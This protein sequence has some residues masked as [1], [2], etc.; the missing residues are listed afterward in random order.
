MLDACLRPETRQVLGRLARQGIKI[1]AVGTPQYVDDRYRQAKPPDVYPI[2]AVRG[3]SFTENLKRSSVKV[4][5]WPHTLLVGRKEW[6]LEQVVPVE[7]R[8][9]S[10]VLLHHAEI[11]ELDAVSYRA[12]QARETTNV[13]GGRGSAPC[14]PF[15]VW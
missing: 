9:G 12:E 10:S 11:L 3:S 5:S 14:Y 13:P 8:I 7:P 6:T 1:L 2:V 15:P 4:T